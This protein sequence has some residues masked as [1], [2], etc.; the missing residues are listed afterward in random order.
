MAI[1]ICFL[2]TDQQGAGQ[3][4]AVNRAPHLPCPYVALLE[5]LDICPWGHPILFVPKD[6]SPLTRFHFT[7]IFCKAVQAIGRPAEQFVA[8]SFCIGAAMLA[9]AAGWATMDIYGIGRW[10]S[11]AFKDYI[12]PFRPEVYSQDSGHPACQGTWAR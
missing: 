1:T 3:H 9:A 11:R 7:A 12:R 8:H 6:S 10:K 5:Y 4:I 2:K